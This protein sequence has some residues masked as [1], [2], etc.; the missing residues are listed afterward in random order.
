MFY[1]SDFFRRFLL[2]SI[3]YRP[4]LNHLFYKQ[5]FRGFGPNK[6]LNDHKMPYSQQV[7]KWL[8]DMNKWLSSAMAMVTFFN[9]YDTFLKLR[10]NFKKTLFYRV[11]RKESA[12]MICLL[13]SVL[14]K[15]LKNYGRSRN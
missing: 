13:F 6:N 2:N 14:N 1:E 12:F 15:M 7:D 4:S 9:K 3:T 11:R 10:S 5:I 8:S